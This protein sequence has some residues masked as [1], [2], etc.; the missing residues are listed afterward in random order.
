MEYHKGDLRKIPANNQ[1]YPFSV[2]Y[3]VKLDVKS[4]IENE[5]R[6][7]LQICD[8]INA[9]GQIQVY[10]VIEKLIEGEKRNGLDPITITAPSTVIFMKRF[11]VLLIYSEKP[12]TIG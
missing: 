5:N 12:P 3:D 7:N 8:F 2:W 9:L 10:L 6:Q 1:L 4:E 11:V